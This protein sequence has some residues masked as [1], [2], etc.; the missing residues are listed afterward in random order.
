MLIVSTSVQRQALRFCDKKLSITGVRSDL[1]QFPA[2]V[3]TIAARC[4]F[5]QLNGTLHTA[6]LGQFHNA[7]SQSSIWL[8]GIDSPVVSVIRGT[9]Q[10][11][12][13]QVCYPNAPT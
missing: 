6:R 9:V 13:P 11:P 10:V 12:F 8:P 7:L 4:G 1:P 3:W 2:F 5:S